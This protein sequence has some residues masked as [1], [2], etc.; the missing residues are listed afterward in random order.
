MD[1]SS[2]TNDLKKELSAFPRPTALG[3]QDPRAA[4]LHM[5]LDGVDF[6]SV[7]RRPRY[8]RPEPA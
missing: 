2:S 5:L 3:L 7:K 1:L 6:E 4:D 8:R